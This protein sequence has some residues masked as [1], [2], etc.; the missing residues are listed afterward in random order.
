MLAPLKMYMLLMEGGGGPEI[1]ILIRATPPLP[2]G[3][4]SQRFSWLIS[5]VMVL[6]ALRCSVA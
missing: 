3:G 5:N 1:M 6:I 4:S 2:K